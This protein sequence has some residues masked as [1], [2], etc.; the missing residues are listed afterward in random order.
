MELLQGVRDK[1]EL[2]IIEQ[3]LNSFRLLNI[4]QDILDLAT[5]YIRD[6]RLSHSLALPDAVIGATA[7]IYQVPLLTY[8]RKDFRFLPKIQLFE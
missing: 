3:K 2:R 8:N 5:Q 6:Y 7:V 1:R 4:Q